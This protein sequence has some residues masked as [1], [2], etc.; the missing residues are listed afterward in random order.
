[1]SYEQIGPGQSESAGFVGVTD[2]PEAADN[3]CLAGSPVIVNA[4]GFVEEC[5]TNPAE[6]AGIA[7]QDGHD[8]AVAGTH[9]IE[10]HRVLSGKEQF[11]GVLVTAALTA[12]MRGLA[13]GM[14]KGA[15]GIW[16]FDLAGVNKTVV[17][18]GW[19]SQVKIGDVNPRVE[20]VPIV[21]TIQKIVA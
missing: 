13:A 4:A 18:E 9:R 19:D 7:A 14:V 15:D 21:A 11:T 3:T 20:V 16:Y 5:A 8:D 6:W 17:I 1:M 10:Y 12:T 2:G